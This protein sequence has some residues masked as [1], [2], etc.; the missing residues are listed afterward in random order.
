MDENVCDPRRVI[1]SFIPCN[2]VISVRLTSML[3]LYFGAD[4]LLQCTSSGWLPKESLIDIASGGVYQ[5]SIFACI[6]FRK[7]CQLSEGSSSEV[8]FIELLYCLARLSKARRVKAYRPTMH[9]RMAKHA[10]TKA[11]SHP[12]RSDIAIGITPSKPAPKA[13]PIRPFRPSD[14]P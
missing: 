2:A 13:R 7:S 10:L 14:R 6:C 5:P 8:G 1:S 11:R 4:A 3:H 9:Q 12:A